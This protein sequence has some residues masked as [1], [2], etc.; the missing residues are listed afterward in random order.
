MLRPYEAFP[1]HLL[2]TPRL[3][4][5][6]CDVQG[7]AIHE[8]Q[9]RQALDLAKWAASGSLSSGQLRLLL[10]G[11]PPLQRRLLG[12]QDKREAKDILVAA[13]KRYQMHLQDQPM[14]KEPPKAVHSDNKWTDV[15]KKT[16]KPKA[17]QKM[18]QDHPRP[19]ELRL[20]ADDWD[21]PVRT[22]AKLGQ[23]GVYLAQSLDH[24][25]KLERQFAQARLPTA[26]ISLERLRKARSCVKQTLR[27][28]ELREGRERDRIVEGYICQM[29]ETAVVHKYLV[30][31]ARTSRPQTTSTVLSMCI[32]RNA[33]SSDE[34]EQLKKAVNVKI[35]N[36]YFGENIKMT[37]LDIFRIQCIDEVY[38]ALLRVKEDDVESWMSCKGPFTLSPMG[39]QLKGYRL[40]WDKTI[41]TIQQARERF[42]E[43]PG[44]VGCVCTKAGRFA[45][46]IREADF[47]KAAT[48]AGKAAGTTYRI[49]GLPV[50][51]EAKEVAE[52]M[53][54]VGWEVVPK[55]A[56]RRI[57]KGTA[58]CLV[59]STDTP[60][61]TAFAITFGHGELVRL[62]V[63]T[64]IKQYV[65]QP[66][67][68]DASPTSWI[69]VASD[70]LMRPLNL[71]MKNHLL[72]RQRMSTCQRRRRAMMMRRTTAQTMPLL[73]TGLHQSVGHSR[74]TFA[75]RSWKVPLER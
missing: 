22:E 3:V 68:P 5:H 52:I 43:L 17:V 20:L 34:W 9:Y 41:E 24:G 61:A 2:T 26:I 56:S 42:E 38:Q 57:R 50:D 25:K 69:Q 39:E 31:Q 7:A 46:R 16:R 32:T 14:V 21:V 65:V 71:M 47:S 54:E 55:E 45:G 70:S 27:V 58:T 36:E 28:K 48:L 8:D 44:Y 60:P 40:I 64:L 72:Q 74:K 10:R 49:V 30:R 6:P 4:A 35:F 53:Q 63:E 19:V 37:A 73:S 12:K 29:A 33:V 23:A 75:W 15:V 11:E 13:A 51:V 67:P 1:Q 59:S 18:T 62:Q 66:K